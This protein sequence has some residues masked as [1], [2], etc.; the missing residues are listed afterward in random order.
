[1][2]LTGGPAAEETAK[3]ILIF[4]TFFDILNVTN[5]TNGTR[6]KKPFLRHKEDA[7][8]KVSYHAHAHYWGNDTMYMYIV[9]IC[10]NC[11]VIQ[12]DS[13]MNFFQAL[14]LPKYPV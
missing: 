11:S 13:I 10:K 9:T 6:Y 3:F 4:D 14:S 12:H 5:F 7:R 2:Q 1:M 8:L